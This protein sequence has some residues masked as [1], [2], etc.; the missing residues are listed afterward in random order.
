MSSPLLNYASCDL[1]TQIWPRLQ[2]LARARRPDQVRLGAGVE[3]GDGDVRPS[4]LWCQKP[5]ISSTRN[6]FHALSYGRLLNDMLAVWASK[7]QMSLKKTE[8]QFYS[9]SR[10]I[11]TFGERPLVGSLAYE[12][13]CLPVMVV[14]HKHVYLYWE[15]ITSAFYLVN[16][17]HMTGDSYLKPWTCD[18]NRQSCQVSLH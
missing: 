16:S 13:I 5:R 8:C 6:G 14:K 10:T 4:S 15:Q 11:W 3:A 12:I 7:P 2:H 1:N 18:S 9:H 17:A